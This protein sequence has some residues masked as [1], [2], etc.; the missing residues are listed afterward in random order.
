MATFRQKL[1][2]FRQDIPDASKKVEAI[3]A[4]IASYEET[5]KTLR[6]QRANILETE[7]ELKQETIIA[8]QKVKESKVLEQTFAT[9]AKSTKA[10]DEKLADNK[11]KLNK[12]K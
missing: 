12:L 10:L 6:L 11:D 2:A 3:D 4:E 7:S 1:M 9:L 5:M 8:I